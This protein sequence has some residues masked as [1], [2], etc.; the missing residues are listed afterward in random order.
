MK[1][2]V[3]FAA[4]LAVSLSQL[5]FWSSRPRRPAQQADEAAE[6]VAETRPKQTAQ[7][8]ERKKEKPEDEQTPT[9]GD[10]EGRLEGLAHGGGAPP[11]V[12][13]QEAL[14]ALS[15]L[16]EQASEQ[17]NRPIEFYGKVVDENGQPI[18]RANVHFGLLVFPETYLETN[19]LTDTSG[20]FS[21]N[22]FTGITAFVK[23]SKL[24]YGEV[25]GTNQ[26]KFD[27]HV[28]PGFEGF[29][30]DPGN[31]ITFALHKQG[32]D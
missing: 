25:K 8:V 24:G 4:V 30:P 16:A 13:T 28:V 6:P 20:L 2:R 15:N 11:N 19:V 17:M 21:V 5:I 10:L 26:S 18:E 1:A 29:R 14:L 31:P 32:P 9:N 12:L 23:V 7:S 27:Y 3:L 22:N